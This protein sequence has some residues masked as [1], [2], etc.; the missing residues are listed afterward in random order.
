[1]QTKLG[2]LQ[3]FWARQPPAW[4]AGPHWMEAGL[5]APSGASRRGERRKGR[6]R[7]DDLCLFCFTTHLFSF[8]FVVSWTGVESGPG[9]LLPLLFTLWLLVIWRSSRARKEATLDSI[10]DCECLGQD[11]QLKISACSPSPLALQHLL[12]FKAFYGHLPLPL[13][14]RQARDLG[15]PWVGDRTSRDHFKSLKGTEF[16]MIAGPWSGISRWK[17][18]SQFEL[19]S[20]CQWSVSWNKGTSSNIQSKQLDLTK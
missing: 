4:L 2:F 12:K 8:G 16:Y 19:S 1:M 5:V 15:E 7:E 6:W 14:N 17:Q 20:S 11:C 18:S 13:W 9:E 3:H 10:S